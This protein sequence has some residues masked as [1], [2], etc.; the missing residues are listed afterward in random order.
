MIKR[1]ILLDFVSLFGPGATL[2]MLFISQSQKDIT[3]KVW[4]DNFLPGRTTFQSSPSC[5]WAVILT[6]VEHCL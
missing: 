3:G 4:A 1:D 2:I 5:G 6:I